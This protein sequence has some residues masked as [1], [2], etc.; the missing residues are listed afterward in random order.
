MLGKYFGIQVEDLRLAGVTM[1]MV[2]AVVVVGVVDTLALVR[3]VLVHACHGNT[4][5]T[6]CVY[7]TTPC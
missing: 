1:L 7:R 5:G 3:G 2:T 6:A 4:V